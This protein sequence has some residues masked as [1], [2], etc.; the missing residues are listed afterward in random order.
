M[1]PRLAPTARERARA[2]ITSEI[3]A[4]AR[5][6]V[7]EAGAASLSLRAVARE[8]G[9][10]SSAV[11]RYFPSRDDL[12]TRLIIDAYDAVGAAAE[13]GESKVAREDIAGR[14]VATFTA[15]RRW[16]LANPH[17]YALVYGTPV[18]GYA[19]PADTVDPAIRVSMVMFR[20]LADGTASG[21]IAT[22]DR[23]ETT[24]AV[25]KDFA[26]FRALGPDVPDPVLSRGLIAWTQ[27]YGHISYE[28]F[29]HLHGG[30]TDYDG[31]F[32]LQARR[33]AAYV[34]AGSG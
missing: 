11:Y 34:I 26:N 15:V 16:A 28:L 8:V 23:I 3:L 25:R 6:Q 21:A 18:P 5:R 32:D 30:I 19:A 24:R 33:V 1:P 7:A 10:V 31:F 20:I 29:G 12:L 4:V 27:M 13:A 22:D 9:M 17:E 14:I 2:E